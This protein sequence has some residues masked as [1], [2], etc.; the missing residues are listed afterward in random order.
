MTGKGVLIIAAI[1]I[2]IAIAIG[3]YASGRDEQLMNRAEE[4]GGGGGGGSGNS[5]MVQVVIKS[6]SR[7]SA[8]IKDSQAESHIVEG[9]G[10]RTIPITCTSEGKYSLTVQKSGGGSG[11]LNVEVI[12]EGGHSSQR[13]TTTSSNGIVSL[14]GTC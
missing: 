1:I 8:N 14:T 5:N 12:T 10:D 11:T 2:A 3:L 9:S 6:D 4:R 13:S 7:W